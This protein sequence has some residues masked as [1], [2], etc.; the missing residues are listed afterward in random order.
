MGLGAVLAQVFLN[1]EHLIAYLN[2]KLNPAEQKYSAIEW[3]A[4][5][6][7]WAVE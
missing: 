5:A 3:E 2:R 6:M 1:Q 7:K 4:L